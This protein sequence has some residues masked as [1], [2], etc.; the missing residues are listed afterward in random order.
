MNF[1]AMRHSKNLDEVVY[2]DFIAALD[3][4]YS[5]IE[6]KKSIWESASPYEPSSDEGELD[7]ERS[8]IKSEAKVDDIA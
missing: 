1:L 4:D 6:D 2:K 3:P 8:P 7:S 5:Y